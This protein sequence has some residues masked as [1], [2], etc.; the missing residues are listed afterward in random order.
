MR[1]PA[2]VKAVYFPDATKGL[3]PAWYVETRVQP[4]DRTDSEYYAHVISAV[5]GRVL[6]RHFQQA[7]GDPQFTY[8][9]WAENTPLATPQP[10]P[11]GRNDIPN[12]AGAPIPPPAYAA[13]VLI[14]L[15]NAPF[16]A[17][18]DWLASGATE[19]NGNNVDSYADIVPD[20]GYT[21]GS[22]LRATLTGP[23]TFD[24]TYDVAQT[25]GSSP[26]QRM[27]AVT[28][29]FYIVNWLHDFFYDAGF[30][31]IDGNA[32]LSNYGRGGVEGDPILAEGQD[33]S[34]L[35]NANMATPSDGGSPRMQMFVFSGPALTS[36]QVNPIGGPSYLVGIAAGFGEQTFNL[37]DDFVR[38]EP[39]FGCTSLT[40]GAAVTGKIAF[41]DR[42]PTGAGACGFSVKA[43]N[44]QAAGAIG[45]VIGN[46]V[47]S[48]APGVAPGMGGTDPT[49]TIPALS[50]N[51][52]DAEAIR[53]TLGDA[54]PDTATMSRTNGVDRD[55]TI[56]GS[57]MAHEWGHY[58]SNRL[59][60]NGGG[61]SNNQGRSMGEG[62]GDFTAMMMMVKEEDRAA[63]STPDFSDTYG[64]ATYAPA[65]HYNGIRRYP[66]SRDLTKNP[67]MFRHIVDGNPL[68]AT[69]PPAI[70][71]PN[72][73]V[74]NAG[75]VW[76]SALWDC[77]SALLNATPPGQA[78][79]E[80]TQA[81]MKRY[82]VGGYKLTPSAP[83]YLEARDAVLATMV[84]E[85]VPDFEI[86]AAQFARR[87][88]GILA[89][90]AP[91][92]STTHAG[93]V[94][95]TTVG[96]DLSA[97]DVA[98]DDGLACDNDGYIDLDE[99]GSIT[100]D[101]QN[102]GWASLATGTLNVA[103][104]HAGLVITGNP[105]TLAASTPYSSQTLN[106]PVV[107]NSLPGSGVIQLTATPNGAIIS[108]PGN[109]ASV[110]VRVGANEAAGIAATERFDAN[111]FGWTNEL[112]N[113][114]S[115][116][117]AWIRTPMDATGSR[118]A[119]GPDSG[120]SGTTSIIS[121]P[122]SVGS[123]PFSIALT[124]RYQFEG[125]VP[126]DPTNWDGGQIE[127][128]TNN[129]ASWDQIGGA[130]YD[131]T[132]NGASGNP[133]EGQA[134][135]VGTSVGYPA[136]MVDTI[137]LGTTYANQTVKLRFTVGTDAGAGA[138]GWELH[139]VAL[140]GA[141]TPFADVVPETIPCGAGIFANSFE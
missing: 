19:T 10:S 59:V 74:H 58:I 106:L 116:G 42:G 31:E 51:F 120:S 21:P 24:R 107:L 3:T 127:I 135:Y 105:A 46:L 109:A 118:V 28:N 64:A 61:L 78:N 122:I 128:S 6:F 23:A 72:A 53:A 13:P 121:L 25:P 85:S 124:H 126:A 136:T 5:D 63:G 117:F 94:E 27:A 22:D 38:A 44:A 55:G 111:S 101:V 113:G 138:P 83:T 16:S 75:E 60:G 110:F 84:A 20:N 112:G 130:T 1:E 71:G 102:S 12:P 87:G 41:I 35:N 49:V 36:L 125:G 81:R 8:R 26:N 132:I 15:D 77:Y 104:S 76:T 88:M 68:P 45:V 70:G 29:Q 11:F 50:V 17:D 47:D 123:G 141:G 67:L 82:L 131:G 7:D 30:K 93:A 119:L 2:R 54:N 69:P 134:A 139:T 43:A 9:V 73:E 48:N 129:G 56:D 92:D 34:G 89:I 14:T 97:T 40:N 86:C 98:A 52:A 65:D 140:T 79:F 108:P 33:F 114:A 99:A 95:D 18:D 115:A 96:A 80:N 133:F 62:W 39:N 57:I 4:T 32:Q 103:T 100:I 91:R 37:T 90:D 66:Y 137:N